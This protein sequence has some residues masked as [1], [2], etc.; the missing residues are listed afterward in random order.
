MKPDRTKAPKFGTIEDIHILKPQIIRFSNG[1]PVYM[2]HDPLSEVVKFEI[3]FDAGEWHQNKPLIAKTCN[4]LLQEGTKSHD[5]AEI[6][7]LIDHI[8]AYSG[9]NVDK[10]VASAMLL[11]VPHRLDQA[12]PVFEEIVKY[13]TFPNRERDIFLSNAKQRHQINMQK[14]KFLASKEF[15]TLVFGNNNPYGVVANLRDFD[16]VTLK[17]L[18]DFH[19][20]MYSSSQAF[21]ILSGKITDKMIE[22]ISAH[23]GEPF[24]QKTKATRKAEKPSD[25][26]GN[27]VF[28]PVEGAVQSAIRIGR[29][30]FTRNHPDFMEFQVL[31]TILGGY[32]GSRLMANIREDKGFTYGIG[33]SLSAFRHDGAFSIASEVGSDVCQEAID[34]IY[35]EMEILKTKLVPASELDTVRNYMLGTILRNMDGALAVSERLKSVIVSDVTL[36]YFRQLAEAIKNIKPVKMREL[37]NKYFDRKDMIEVVAGN[38]INK[39]KK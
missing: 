33:S 7:T 19:S 5:S 30:M 11:C 21:I 3:V 37:A 38:P 20:S 24:G 18:K 31:N 27:Q 4:S 22:K 13:P 16:N 9:F 36:E 6:A 2:I 15:F 23:F 29:R 26:S 34:E 28:I 8:G 17:S 10:D 25:V 1:I 32:F 39:K 12:L 14:V 35:K